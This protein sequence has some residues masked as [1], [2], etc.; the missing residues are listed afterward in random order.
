MYTLHISPLGEVVLHFA[1]IQISGFN[2]YISGYDEDHNRIDFT[3]DRFCYPEDSPYGCGYCHI[4]SYVMQ[5]VT[6]SCN[7]YRSIH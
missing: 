2:I 4:V 3:M 6:T 7:I 5:G 1:T